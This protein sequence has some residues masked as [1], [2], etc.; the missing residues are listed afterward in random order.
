MEGNPVWFAP[1]DNTII[2]APKPLTEFDSALREV[3]FIISKSRSE[4]TKKAY[5]FDWKGFVAFCQSYQKDFLPASPET[6]CAYF[7]IMKN[8]RKL[9]TIERYKSSIGKAHELAGLENPMRDPM[10]RDTLDGLRRTMNPLP[11]QKKPLLAEQLRQISAI[12]PDSLMGLRDRAILLVG[13]QGAFRREELARLTVEDLTFSPKGI[14]VYLGRSKADQEG[15]GQYK[16]ITPGR[17]KETC[18]VSALQAWLEASGITTGPLFRATWPTLSTEALHPATIADIVKRCCALVNLDEREYA[19][20]S[21]RAGMVTQAA[22][23]NVP[24][25]DIVRQTGQKVETAMRYIRPHSIFDNNAGGK[26]GL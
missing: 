18:P 17:F 15:K 16:A 9:S 8:K 3:E 20:H 2:P 25:T 7:A 13:F 24:V 22:L 21:L 1:Q 19:G 6:I 4:N 14:S 10:V 23:N 12:L 26:V 5:R 11:N